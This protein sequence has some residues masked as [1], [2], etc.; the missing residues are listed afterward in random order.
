MTRRRDLLAIGAVGAVALAIPPILRRRAPTLEPIP[1]APGFFAAP[2]TAAPDPFA[3]I[4]APRLPAIDLCA[5]LFRGTPAPHAAFFSDHR[6][7]NCPRAAAALTEL[8]KETPGLSV[9]WHEWPIFGGRSDMLARLAIAARAQGVDAHRALYTASGPTS[10][11]AASLG[12]DA[13]QLADD[14]QSPRTTAQIVATTA[15]AARLGLIGTP[16]IV[17]N[18]SVLVGAKSKAQMARAL[19]VHP[20]PCTR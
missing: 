14:M 4:D 16:S 15:A 2:L 10:R 9:I 8:A 6:C 3:G 5:T 1:G 19:D 13:K 11:I 7:P 17:L 18:G 20:S 12:L